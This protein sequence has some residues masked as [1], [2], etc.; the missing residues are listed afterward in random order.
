MKLQPEEC[1]CA[2]WVPLDTLSY[3][4]QLGGDQQ[5]EPVRGAR[6]EAPSE[7]PSEASSEASAPLCER[8][9]LAGADGQ[10]RMMPSPLFGGVYPNALGSGVGRGHMLALHQL[11]SASR[12]SDKIPKW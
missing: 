1:D 8:A 3:F 4:G 7:A 6:E 10:P 5:E 2:C 11:A 9:D 12:L